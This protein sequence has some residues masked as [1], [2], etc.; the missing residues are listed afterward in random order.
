MQFLCEYIFSS[1]IECGFRCVLRLA[2]TIG[3]FPVTNKVLTWLYVGVEH[4]AR[5]VVIAQMGV[6]CSSELMSTIGGGALAD[7]CP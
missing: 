7:Y 3:S 1:L 5:L 2:P 4:R 6:I